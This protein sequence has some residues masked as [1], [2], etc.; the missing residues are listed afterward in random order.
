VP[1]TFEEKLD[2]YAE[3]TVKV[4]LGLQAGQK[5]LVRAPIEGAPLTRRVVE[6]AYQ[7]GARLVQ[8]LWSDDAVQLA[9]FQHAPPESFDEITD[10]QADA[11]LKGTERGDAF[12]AIHASDP[13][14]LK[15]QDPKIVAKVQKN[16]QEYL[17]PFATRIGNSEVNWCIIGVPIPGWT[18]QVF[19]DT[20]VEEATSMLW[21][22]IFR[23]CRIDEPDPVAAWRAHLAK[24]QSWRERLNKKQYASLRFRGPGTDLTVG[25]PKRHNWLG[26]RV[27]TS[28]E[29]IPFVP[30]LPT[31]EIFCTPHKDRVEGTVAS[32][33]PLNHAGTLIEDFSLRFENGR[34][35]EANAAA[36]VE[37]LRHLIET[38]E[39][40]GRLGEVALV[41]DSSPISQSGLLFYS[42]LYDENASCHLAVGR[43][44]RACL[45]G[46]DEMSESDF[47]AAGG[48][49]SLVHAD[50]MIGSDKLDLDGITDDGA[51]EAVMRG[52]EW[53]S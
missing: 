32:T 47:Q 21:N 37:V 27:E 23:I 18:R 48:N 11:M 17:L 25:L 44:F 8:V 16:L 22:A 12:L 33:K 14:L 9:R 19:P 13:T 53:V 29:K 36:N 51:T 34:V 35:I 28:R 30:N 1:L 4:G 45:E 7:A 49:M 41:P 10:A 39:G 24:L 2:R 5:L 15:D 52:G 31:E 40:A 42:T 6:K 46:G 50:F 20:D 3:L 43:S 26:G 38:D